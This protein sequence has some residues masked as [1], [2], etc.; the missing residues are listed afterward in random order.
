MMDRPPPRNG[1]TFVGYKLA[2]TPKSFYFQDH[3]WEEPQ[4]MPASQ[5]DVVLD[6][7]TDEIRVIASSWICNQ[8]DLKE[9][10]GR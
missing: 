1:L 7:D 2:E 6:L 3:F 5:C 8:K 10:T 9:E 4:W